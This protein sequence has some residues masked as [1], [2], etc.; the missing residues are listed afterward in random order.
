MDDGAVAIE[1]GS[2]QSLGAAA[3]PIRFAVF[4]DEQKV[5]PE[6]EL[7]AHDRLA[8]HALARDARGH[9]VGTGRLLPDGHIGR[10]AVLAAMRG[11]GVGAALVRALMAA[12]RER[13]HAEVVL[14][15]QTHAVEFYRRLGFVPEGDVFDDAGLPHRQMRARLEPLPER[16]ARRR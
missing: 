7:D 16:R 5:P 12:A 14:S 6:L 2:W 11:C 10:V 9:A 3:A 15:A 13:R 1:L 8:L 4:V